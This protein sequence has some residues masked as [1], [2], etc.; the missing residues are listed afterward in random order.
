MNEEITIHLK[1][2]TGYIIEVSKIG[3]KNTISYLKELISELQKNVNP[4]K[5]EF[6]CG[7]THLF[8][9]EK[10]FAEYG[11]ENN[12]IIM[13]MIVDKEVNSKNDFVV[14]S[15][16]A[17]GA[18]MLSKLFNSSKG[19]SCKEEHEENKKIVSDKD[20]DDFIKKGY[21]KEDVL[22]AYT[23]F[24]SYVDRKKRMKELRKKRINDVDK[25]QENY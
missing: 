5:C 4:R 1:F 20:L 24:D 11:I 14:K 22:K 10:T 19:N 8:D 18:N 6:F 16:A 12:D 13:V 7:G 25:T 15:E 17:K 3:T 2:L 23:E 9:M 21:E